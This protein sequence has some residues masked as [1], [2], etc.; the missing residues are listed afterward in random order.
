M[1]AGAV[2]ALIKALGGGSGGG[3]GSSGGGMV[4]TLSIDFQAMTMTSDKKWQ[5]IHDAVSQMPVSV[6]IAQGDTIAISN[7]VSVSTN[8]DDEYSVDV[9]SWNAEESA[10]ISMTL[11]TASADGYPAIQMG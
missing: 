3:G 1:T 9:V 7:I 5:E 2:L 4:V 8:G 6:Y 11:S 10:Y